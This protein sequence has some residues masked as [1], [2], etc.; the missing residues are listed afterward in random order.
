M[1]WRGIALALLLLLTACAAPEVP[2][3]P[4]ELETPETVEMPEAP[5][6]AGPAVY[7]DWSR[8]APYEPPEPVYTLHP[9][10]RAAG[11]LEARGDYGVLLPYIGKYASM[12]AY[13]IDALPL[14]GLVTDR[15]ALVTGPVYSGVNFSE[16]FLV[17]YQGDPQGTAGG[18]AYDGGTFSRTVAAADGR[19]V[20]PLPEGCYYVGSGQ[21]LLVT[22]DASGGLD[23]WNTEGEIIT[24]FDGALFS[25]WFGEHFLWGEEGGPWLEWTDSRVGYAR[26]CQVDGEYRD[27]GVR[28]YLDFASGA[29]TDA[30][31]EGYPAEIDYEALYSARPQAP[32]VEGCDYLDSITDLVTGE[33]YFYGYRRGGEGEEPAHPLF[34]SRGEVLVE[35]FGYLGSFE[36]GPVLRGGLYA[37]I[38][39]D[40]F[41]LRRI[42]DGELVFRYVM[43][44]NT[45]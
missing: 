37:A 43:R 25:P 30:P 34:D 26:T 27:E 21:G 41:C 6:P 23:L 4:P 29:V 12:E 19:W 13:V 8:L 16:D 11:P 14:F 20:H 10:Y 9:G 1:R 38:E 15:G 44:T 22:A 35:A 40:C 28:L 31:P 2:A 36:T 32:E 42:A 5:P 24:H 45:D 17:L 18:D 33:T 3:E 7:T 39:E